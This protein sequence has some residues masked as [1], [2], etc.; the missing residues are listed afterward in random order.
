MWLLLC[1]FFEHIVNTTRNPTLLDL[2]SNPP[3]DKP[4][5]Y[6]VKGIW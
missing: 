3:E 1:S 4:G 5:P 2:A 6:T